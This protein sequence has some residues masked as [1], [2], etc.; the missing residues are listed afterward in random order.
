MARLSQ[1]TYT[2]NIPPGIEVEKLY[3]RLNEAI[4][5]TQAE[6]RIEKGR[7]FITL[8]GTEAQ[9]KET[10]FRVKQ[11]IGELWELYRLRRSGE[12]SVDAIVKEAGRTFPPEALVEALRIRGYSAEYD[13][14]THTVRT[15][16]P[17]DT[18]I[19]FA[20]RIAEVIDELRFR[21]S[22]TAIKRVIA[23]V[24]VGLEVPVD[25]VIEFGLKMRVFE[26]NEE[27]KVVL[28]EEWRRAIRKLTVMLRPHSRVV[29]HGEAEADQA[30]R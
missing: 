7:L 9:I 28:K 4:R 12:A 5:V 1:R 17:A 24:A 8:W 11:V 15:N 16:A 14:D 23:A 18:V 26:E 20:R 25:M 21:V 10:W 3:D 29:G 27:G 30:G 13:S 2:I 19:A 22:G 6:L